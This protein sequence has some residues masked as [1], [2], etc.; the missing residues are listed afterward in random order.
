[1]KRL[2]LL[3]LALALTTFAFAQGTKNFSLGPR[4]GV[5]LAQFTNVDNADSKS[6]L[7]AGLTSTYSINTRSGLT[8][9]L[10]YSVEGVETKTE[11]QVQTDLDYIRFMLAYDIFFRDRED[12]FRPKIYIGPNVGV[13]LSAENQIEGADTEVDVKESYNTLDVGLTLGLGF[14]LRIGGETW[15]N[16]DGR[17]QPGLMNIIDNK[18]NG[19]DA[20]RNQNFQISLGL[21]FGL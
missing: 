18:P 1:M 8:M 2:N 19:V 15:L 11:P 3:F 9:D 16:V 7:V 4:V 10:L 21:A 13:L 14:N 12:D 20:V 6:G 5:N 17:Y